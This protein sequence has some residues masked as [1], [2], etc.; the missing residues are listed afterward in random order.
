M[1]CFNKMDNNY[2]AV[3]IYSHQDKNDHEIDLLQKAAKERIPGV[4]YLVEVLTDSRWTYLIM[5]LIEH[6]DLLHHLTTL[7]ARGVCNAFSFVFKLMKTIHKLKYVH[8]RICFKNIRYLDHI[9]EI[10]L[11][12]FGH[13]KPINDTQVE[14]IDFWSLGV[15]IYTVLCGHAPFNLIENSNITEMSIRILK[16][17]FDR[18]SEQWRALHKS[19]QQLIGKL[20]STVSSC[21]A[22]ELR[23]IRN[24]VPPVVWSNELVDENKKIIEMSATDSLPLMKIKQEAIIELNDIA[25]ITNG[26]GSSSGHTR[27]ES[28]SNHA[29]MNGDAR[30]MSS[31]RPIE[32]TTEQTQPKK[33]KRNK[34]PEIKQEIPTPTRKLRTR[35]R[36]DYA[37]K[38][39]M[40]SAK[41]ENLVQT[42]SVPNNQ[43]EFI[44]VKDIKVLPPERQPIP[45]NKVE[46]RG[47][48]KKTQKTNDKRKKL[49]NPANGVAPV[50]PDKKHSKARVTSENT[51]NGNSTM[52]AQ[53]NPTNSRR[54]RP[55]HRNAASGVAQQTTSTIARPTQPDR[56][57][58]H[59]NGTVQWVSSRVLS[60][61]SI[62]EGVQTIIFRP[63]LPPIKPYRT[64]ERI[65]Y[66]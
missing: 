20:I 25:V 24:T 36:Q 30:K 8:G 52:A 23:R 49:E 42:A 28:A 26:H 61:S 53:N 37:K 32:N 10:R 29:H 17:D 50:I 38:V 5:E 57:N 15:C 3:K 6:P 34:L 63:R 22:S 66:T 44:D 1:K 11:I 58:D 4:V 14:R 12:G 7:D 45:K 13:A 60:V 43:A 27:D 2:Y 19:V 55:N 51:T 46:T 16:N 65:D 62:R 54:R 47:R 56:S 48:P 18:K 35:E 41:T 64:F 39:N 9:S 21:S 40:K 33:R 31:K 59:S